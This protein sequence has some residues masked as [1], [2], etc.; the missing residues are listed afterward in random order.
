VE[1][2]G[3]PADSFCLACFNNIYPVKPDT[4][5]HKLALG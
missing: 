4:T 3:M 1:S 2:T 5:F